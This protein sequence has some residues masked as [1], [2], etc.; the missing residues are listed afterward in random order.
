[1]EIIPDL[2]KF[3]HSENLEGFIMALEDEVSDCILE[4]S[5][6]SLSTS[7]QI[8]DGSVNAEDFKTIIAYFSSFYGNEVLFCSSFMH[9]R[10]E[11][12]IESRVHGTFRPNILAIREIY[13]SA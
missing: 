3:E 8:V 11:I 9:N 7:L 2:S 4:D 5:Y 10:K 13:I 6:G 12:S 1:M